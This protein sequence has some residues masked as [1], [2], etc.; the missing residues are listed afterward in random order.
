MWVCGHV[1]IGE[2]GYVEIHKPTNHAMCVSGNVGINHPG[3]FQPITI[4]KCTGVF[5]ANEYIK[6]CNNSVLRWFY[7]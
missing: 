4:I 5:L 3:S 1:V 2:C 6:R 7:G